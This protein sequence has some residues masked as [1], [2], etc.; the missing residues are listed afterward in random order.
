MF[1]VAPSSGVMVENMFDSKSFP[2]HS[3]QHNEIH[4]W[5]LNHGLIFD[6]KIIKKC[7]SIIQHDE[8]MKYEKFRHEESKFQYLLTR[9]FVRIVLSRYACVKPTEWQFNKGKFG[10]PYVSF[11]LHCRPLYFNLSHTSGLIVCAISKNPLIGVDVESTDRND[12]TSETIKLC[13]SSSEIA[14]INLFSNIESSEYIMSYWT[15]KEAYTKALGLGMSLPFDSFSIV[16]DN[17]KPITVT[18]NSNINITNLYWRFGVKK[19]I[20]NYI[21]SFAVGGRR[22]HASVDVIY[23]DG[24]NYLRD[25]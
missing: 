16:Y 17:N 4:I 2:S 22:D 20:P 1:I 24:S 10:R 8:L 14:R 19:I 12:L 9:A 3:V 18:Q 11:P 13:F 25:F 21:L 23:H 15:L 7:F 5:F 6:K